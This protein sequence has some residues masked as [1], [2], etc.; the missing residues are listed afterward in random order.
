M[1]ISIFGLGYV[2]AVT[3]A[4]FARDGHEIIG[5]DVSPEKVALINAGKS[6][7]VEHGLE[8]LLAEG[9]RSGRIRATTNSEEAIL[10]SDA[11]LISV[12]TPPTERGETDLQY[13]FNVLKDIGAVISQ[14]SAPHAIV[15]RSTVPPGTLQR[16]HD[17]LAEVVN[18]KSIHLAFNP[19]F[20]RE[21]TAIRDYDQPPYTIIGTEDDFAENAVR[22]MYAKVAAPFIVSPP[23]VAEMVKFVANTWHATKVTFANEIGRIAKSFKIDGRDVMDIIVQDT[24]LNIS[25]T[26]MRP[27]F[28]Y[29]GSCLPKD[30]GAL[31]YCAKA[32]DVPV[33]LLNAIPRSNTLQ[34]EI[35]VQEVM[36]SPARRIA[37]FGLAFK[38]GTDDLRESPAVL[39]VKR[40]IGEGYEV[41]IYDKAVH[42]AR[43]V[44]TNL[45]YIERNLPHFE[46]LLVEEPEAALKDAEFAVFTYSTPEFCQ[47]MLNIPQNIRILDLAGLV[48]EPL[49]GKD[50]HGIAW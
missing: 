34:V 48:S 13:V 24:K 42:E 23:P 14:K 16:C 21:G 5:V 7:I 27:G 10:A 25:T 19:E 41:K 29:G 4:C 8:E 35:A 3:A 11:S 30:L 9:V 43:L 39:L 38:P 44:G 50:Y 32:M 12:G 36:R 22:E 31:L 15:L 33:P 26:Y 6:P 37:V 17:F 40:L 28:A 1:K 49:A 18:L 45:A 2:G 47:V 20:L 46:A